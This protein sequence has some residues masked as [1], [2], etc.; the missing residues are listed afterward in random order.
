M[1]EENSVPENE[2]AVDECTDSINQDSKTEESPDE[3][4][5]DTSEEAAADE[6]GMEETEITDLNE[7]AQADF[8]DSGSCGENA[9]WTLTGTG[10]D[11]TLTISGSGE[12]EDYPR[13]KTPWATKRE[14][15]KK[16]VIKEDINTIGDCAFVSFINLTNVSLPESLY[17]IGYSSFGGCKQLKNVNILYGVTAI[18]GCA[19]ADCSSLRSIT[20][21][22]SVRNIGA[23]AFSNCS[24]LTNIKLSNRVTN[25][26][27]YTFSDCS[28]LTN[29]KIPNSVANISEYAF[30]ECGLTSITI[31]GSVININGH[32]FSGCS[33][34]TS[35]DLP[36]SVWNIGEYAF[37][38]CGLTSITIPDSVTNID[39]N[40]FM[41][42]SSLKTVTISNGVTS[43]Q[44]ETFFGC[45]SLSSIT[46]PNGVTIIDDN[47]FNGCSS[48]TN[49]IIPNSVQSIGEGAFWN[50]SKLTNVTIPDGVKN[51]GSC[52][53]LGCSNL[54]SVKIPNS[55][56][57]IEGSAF[58]DDQEKP[59][60][61]I[62]NNPYVINLCKSSSYEYF[63][64][65]APTIK[66]LS[67][68][69][70]S[71][72]WVNIE[73]REDAT[74]YHIKYANNSN[75]ANPKEVMLNGKNALSKAISGLKN[76]KTYYVQVQIF[77]K[78][79]NSTYWS[80]W[81]PVKSVKVAQ[82]PYPTNVSKL[83][84][85]I[86][87]HIKVDWPKTAGASG[88]HIKYADNSSMTGAKEVMVKGNS[89]FTKTLT[90]LKNGKTYYIKIQT[91]RTV[92]GK[93]YWSSWSQAKSIKVDQNPYGSSIKKLT[94]PS[95]KKINITWDKAPSASGYH[96]QYS[97]WPD[98][99]EA[100]D[101]FVN[102]KETLSKTISLTRDGVYYVRIQTFRKIS[103]K[104]YWSS[105]S[106]AKSVYIKG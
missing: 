21:P 56:T 3:E 96:I 58:S 69:N 37:S 77:K 82:T 2:K 27:E 49:I 92:S 81:S 36:E 67:G 51:I 43:I 64:N 59:V 101:V 41:G 102:N 22:D 72:I 52:A 84:T 46:I 80:K 57:N 6:F 45:S 88:Y 97:M 15:I 74:G 16:V 104:T 61:I 39:D 60:I 10:N 32:A 62:T 78:T 99:K 29:I 23:E 65:T 87:S 4:E 42:C 75:M 70:G 76:G 31:P 44:P 95:S 100:K 11:L 24:S 14:K 98:M 18:E 89:T 1:N 85:Y 86:G 28:N 20:I 19:F 30:S 68:Q 53:F 50:C 91:Y 79:W 63:D 105:W 12:M 8:V 93:T 103:G 55:V 7:D 5:F 94:N 90:G 25:I 26:D 66:R 83:S 33:N 47:A 71:D 17:T 54:A 34:L 9:T 38:E 106:V 73:K 13:A 35:I 48:L 40:A